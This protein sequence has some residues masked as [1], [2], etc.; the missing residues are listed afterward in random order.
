M[1]TDMV[2]CFVAGAAG[3]EPASALK[4]SDPGQVRLLADAPAEHGAA[5]TGAP[6][7]GG[8]VC[9]LFDTTEM[10]ANQLIDLNVFFFINITIVF[11]F[12]NVFDAV[13]PFRLVISLAMCANLDGGRPT[14]IDRSRNR[15]VPT[16]GRHEDTSC[17]LKRC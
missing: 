4:W 11:L 12:F 7:L 14:R 8:R 17:M 13:F 6:V 2:F 5:D 15:S 16:S 1:V 3:E 10:E 9:F